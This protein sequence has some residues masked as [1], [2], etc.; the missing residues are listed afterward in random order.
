MTLLNKVQIIKEFISNEVNSGVL[1][2]GQ[3]LPSCREVAQK[4]GV[5]KITVNKA[6]NEL[7]KEHKVYSVP[8]GGFYLME[9]IDNHRL[10]P[11]I[12]DFRTVKPDCRLIPYREF[13]HV[14]NKAVEAYKDDLFGYGEA[15]G[16][17]S[18]RETLRI[19]FAKDGIYT[20][21]EE[22][23]ITNGAQQAIA[24]VLQHLIKNNKGKIL[25][26]APT[27]SLF[28]K[29][30]EQ[31]SITTEIIER[32]RDGFDFKKLEKI[33]RTGE[34]SAFYVIPRHHNPTG[35]TLSEKDKKRI[36]ELSIKYDV[37]IIEDDYL[38]DLGSR[39]GVLPIHYYDTNKKTAYIRSFSKTFMPGIRLG[40]V[41]LPI[42]LVE[43]V[44]MLKQVY[45]LNTSK[46]PQ[47]A[48]D[49]FIKSGMYEKHIKRVKKAYDKKLSKALEILKGL[50]PE[51]WF[52]YVPNH[53]IFI[54]LELPNNILATTLERHLD[55]NNILIK[56]ASDFFPR[57][58]IGAKDRHCNYIRLC[59]SGIPDN[60][61]DSLAKI[62]YAIRNLMDM[63]S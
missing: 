1:K 47:A 51:D 16:L 18:L 8:R 58:W 24:L 55:A 5:N 9:S 37:L 44:V 3:R 34:I 36:A 11:N 41:V 61:I 21:S 14:M 30:V 56:E 2:Y 10:E 28:N 33:F 27:Y 35:Y 32:R 15:K 40:A 22:I 60:S 19:E 46:I 13:N 12:V 45:D 7:E 59:I 57:G 49:Y 20:S 53:G 4:L 43:S 39:K 38:A 54:W 17:S 6:Y 50:C 31:L 29:L 52:Y 48:L 25:V 62:I 63:G 26:E 42:F 23:V